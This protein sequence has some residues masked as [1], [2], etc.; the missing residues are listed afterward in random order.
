L[1]GKRAMSITDFLRGQ[2]D[3]IGSTLGE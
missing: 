3:F 2:P 1:A